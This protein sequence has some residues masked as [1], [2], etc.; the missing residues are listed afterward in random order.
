MCLTKKVGVFLILFSLRLELVE[1]LVFAWAQKARLAVQ[2]TDFIVKIGLL[3]HDH[4]HFE[5]LRVY[6]LDQNLSRLN[7][8]LPVRVCI[9][10]KAVV[11]MVEFVRV[12]T[13]TQLACNPKVDE[14][15]IIVM[16]L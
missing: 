10:S 9:F 16:K 11:E 14:S 7:V 13:V 12:E 5:G 15:T 4:S 8:H 1:Q 2:R 6:H 3:S